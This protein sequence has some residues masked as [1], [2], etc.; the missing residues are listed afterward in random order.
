[1][2]VRGHPIGLSAAALPAPGFGRLWTAN[3]VSNVGDG[4]SLAAGPLLIASLTDNPALISGAV[5]AQQLPWLLFSLI[6]GAY[7]DRLDRRLVITAVNLL[8]GLVLGGLAVAVGTGVA[9]VAL[10]YAAFFLL[11]TAETLADNAGVALVPALVPA[12]RLPGANARL[13][14]SQIVGNQLLGPPLGAWLFVV[15][16]A[17]PFGLDAVSFVL[18]GALIATL[19]RAAG[20]PAEPAPRA[21]LRTEIAEGVRWLWQHRVL[22]MLALS[23]CLMNITFAGTT[24]IMVLWSRERLG[25]GELGYGLLLSCS[26]AGGLLGSVLAGRLARRFG[27]SLLL[28]TGL[29]VETCTHL[30]LALTRTPWVGCLAVGVFGVHAVVW[31]S[32]TVALRQRVVPDALRGR[33]NSV[34]FLFSVGGSALGALQGGFVARAYGITA[35]FW[36]ALGVM[37]LFTVAAWRRFGPATLDAERRQVVLEGS[38]T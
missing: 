15:A 17:A 36:L 29:I 23:I 21:R 5:F 27:A 25:F 31:G 18:A 35:P 16:A 26:A 9:T 32:V 20:R 1:V 28:R 37:V 7:V 10:I 14:G 3:A 6:S 13:I 2:A 34:N 33:V 38:V 22:R 19:P 12:E 11:G 24:S 30:V 4:V 8:R